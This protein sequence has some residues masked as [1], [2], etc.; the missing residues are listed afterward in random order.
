MSWLSKTRQLQVDVYNE[1]LKRLFRK[2]DSGFIEW[3]FKPL[4]ILNHRRQGITLK[5]EQWV[6]NNWISSEWLDFVAY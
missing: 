1:D 6:I 5:A 2:D 3:S 4:F